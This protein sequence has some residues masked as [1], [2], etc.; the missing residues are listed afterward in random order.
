MAE[1][2]CPKCGTR[3]STGEGWDKAAMS[4]LSQAPAVPDMATQVRQ[5][6]F[7]E[8]RNIAP[9]SNVSRLLFILA[10]LAR[11]NL[12]ALSIALVRRSVASLRCRLHTRSNGRAGTM[13]LP[14][15]SSSTGFPF[16]E[17]VPPIPA[18]WPRHLA[19]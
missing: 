4:V 10:C 19:L 15:R 16:W 2:T 9:S 12:G 6:V 11:C 5:H 7:A 14:W 8:V 18:S 13:L 3:F 1:Q 17:P